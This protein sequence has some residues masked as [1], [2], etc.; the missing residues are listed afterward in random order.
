[1]SDRDDYDVEDDRDKYFEDD[2]DDD[3]GGD[4]DDGDDDDDGQD[5]PEWFDSTFPED[6]LDLMDSD[7]GDW[8]YEEFEIGIDYGE[9]T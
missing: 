2:D 6:W 1:M 7:Y 9:D 4:D 5:A 8:D 3:G